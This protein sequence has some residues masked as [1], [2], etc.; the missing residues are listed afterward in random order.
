[1]RTP[2][3][4]EGEEEEDALAVSNCRD[5]EAARSFFLIQ[6]GQVMPAVSPHVCASC[7]INASVALESAR[8]APNCLWKETVRN[9]VNQ[10]KLSPFLTLISGRRELVTVSMHAWVEGDGHSPSDTGISF[11]PK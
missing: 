9:P 5:V 2:R 11:T 8:N 10:D 6:V 7:K 3:A 1:M 4:G